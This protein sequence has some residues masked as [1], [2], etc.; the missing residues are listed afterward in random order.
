MENFSA[1]KN[2][3]LIFVSRLVPTKGLLETVRAAAIL[4]GKGFNVILDVLGDGETRRAA[5]DLAENLQIARFVNFHGH[6]PEET[7]QEFYAGTDLLVFPTFHI[8]GFPM[9]VFNA[10]QF[11]LPI[12]TTAV[13]GMKDVI[14]DGET[15]LLIPIR[16]P[17][18]IEAAV[19][20]FVGDR[21]LRER[22]GRAAQAA[23]LSKYTWDHVA[24][25][26]EEAY[27]ALKARRA[28]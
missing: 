23:A 21:A 12:V 22:V 13:C 10:L 7:V 14:E 3:R 5:E 15:G 1:N 9:V 6:V 17:H 20:R 11:G 2:F 18:A 26:V 24:L 25:P 4:R 27:L 8:E 19:S 28:A 16:S